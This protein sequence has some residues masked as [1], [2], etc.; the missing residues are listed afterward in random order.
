MHLFRL[1]HMEDFLDC[2]SLK[3]LYGISQNVTML[4]AEAPPLEAG[5]AQLE[6]EDEVVLAEAKSVPLGV[7]GLPVDLEVE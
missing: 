4:E 7:L 1:E 3:D 5:A 2:D 6:S